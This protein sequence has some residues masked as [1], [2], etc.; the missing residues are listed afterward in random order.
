MNTKLV[1]FFGSVGAVHLVAG[2][3]FLA[4]GCTQEDPPMPPGIYVPK[5]SNEAHSVTTAVSEPAYPGTQLQDPVASDKTGSAQPVELKGKEPAAQPVPEQ[6][7]GHGDRVYIVVK[8]DS[9]WLIARKNGLTL[10]ELASYNNLPANARLKIGQKLY[11]PAAGKKAVKSKPARAQ[12]PKAKAA[13]PQGKKNA[14][15]KKIAAK[16][17]KNLPPDGIYTVKS[18]DNFSTIA[19][20]HGLK[21]SDIIAANPGVDS[22]RL[23]IGQKLRLTADAPAV[24]AVKTGSKKKAAPAKKASASAKSDSSAPA[25]GT[26]DEK[27]QPSA[28]SASESDD[29]LKSV[30]DIKTDDKSE[31][32][33]NEAVKAVAPDHNPSTPGS[34]KEDKVISDS[35]YNTAVIVAEDTTL[36]ELCKKYRIPDDSAVRKLN[37]SIPADGKIKA[38]TRVRLIGAED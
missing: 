31:S 29:L 4:G 1:V 14:S 35:Q 12:E 15:R 24:P 33:S 38:G 26:S 13:A 9:L 36:Q 25:A 7:S 34:V 37:P 11:I 21:V 19:K 8:N 17:V 16:R 10:E 22:S 6:D 23:K 2:G 5:Q 18:G 3:L 20:R 27:K 30:D 28:P 32:A